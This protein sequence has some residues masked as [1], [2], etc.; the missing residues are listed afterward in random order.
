MSDTKFEVHG[1]QDVEIPGL[2]L[3]VFEVPDNVADY[4]G[5]YLYD[6]E[7]K[8]VWK[9]DFPTREEAEKAGRFNYYR[10]LYETI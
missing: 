10:E 1:C 9:S 5:L 3:Q 7:G 6:E 4:F 2:G 8:L